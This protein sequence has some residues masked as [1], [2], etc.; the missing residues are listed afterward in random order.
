MGHKIRA[1]MPEIHRA[2]QFVP[3][4]AVKGLNEAL[5]EKEKVYS[6]K[7]VLSEDAADELNAVL[8]SLSQGDKVR[9]IC[10][11]GEEYKTL[12]GDIITV[13]TI[14][15]KLRITGIDVNFSDILSMNIKGT[16]NSH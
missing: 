11:N 1:K 12:Y 14:N 13:D 10:Y 2:K 9:L 6:Q 16:N 4:A 8:N 7:F 15:R 5:E 3:F